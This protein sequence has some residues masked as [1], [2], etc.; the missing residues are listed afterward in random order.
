MISTVRRGRLDGIGLLVV[1]EIAASVIL[2]FAFKDPRLVLARPACYTAIAGIYLAITSIVA[3]PLSVA[4]AA[5]IATNGD[6]VRLEAYGQT[7][8]VSAPFR[9]AHRQISMALS[10]WHSIPNCTAQS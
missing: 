2:L 8:H 1:I 4:A 7:W 10:T 6:P 5:P 9:R 3:R